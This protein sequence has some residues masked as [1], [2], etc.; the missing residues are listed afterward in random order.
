MSEQKIPIKL[1]LRNQLHQPIQ[2]KTIPGLYYCPN[3]LTV[4][5]S[6]HFLE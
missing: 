2:Y 6:N 5:E 4:T 3:F 1:K